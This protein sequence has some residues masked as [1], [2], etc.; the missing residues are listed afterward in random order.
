M[1]LKKEFVDEVYNGFIESIEWAEK[2]SVRPSTSL[3]EVEGEW[4]SVDK[5]GL[6]INKSDLKKIRRFVKGVLPQ[7]TEE[8]ISEYLKT[9]GAF[10]D[11]LNYFGHDLYLSCAG[12][13]TGFWDRGLKELGTRLHN[14]CKLNRFSCYLY[15]Y[16]NQIRIEIA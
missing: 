7:F 10:G 4:A 15:V 6:P 16:R 2:V 3:V 1:K 13:G 5:V 14:V 12:H 8:D 11:G 9:R